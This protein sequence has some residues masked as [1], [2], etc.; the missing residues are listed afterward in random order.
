MA[1]M[2]VNC[3]ALEDG[4]LIGPKQVYESIYHWNTAVY[5]ILA[6][7]AIPLWIISSMII[8]KLKSTCESELRVPLLFVTLVPPTLLIFFSI[9]IIIPSTGPFIQLLGD[10]T[11]CIGMVEF[12]LLTTRLAG[13]SKILVQRC[14]DSKTGLP[15]AAPPFVCLAVVKQPIVTLRKL[16][17]IQLLPVTLIFLKSAL[18]IIKI[19]ES[20]TY[21]PGEEPLSVI[22]RY[23]SIPIGLVGVYTYTIYLILVAQVMKESP[24]RTLG[25]VLL[26]FFVLSDATELFFLFLKGTKMLTCV[27]PALPLSSVEHLLKNCIKGFL[28]FAA[29][30]PYLKICSGKIN[31]FQM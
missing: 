8:S 21:E 3:S 27:P 16:N 24:T 15:I 14:T 6:L 29:G 22:A 12:V 11:I 19:F 26:G 28:T 23:L 5:V 1:D 2:T 4:S 20:A 13:G 17:I 18:L 7:H 10:M 31:V 30:M 25:F 9:G